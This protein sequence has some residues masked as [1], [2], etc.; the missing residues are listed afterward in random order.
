MAHQEK[1]SKRNLD[2]RSIKE[3]IK[4][5]GKK[6]IAGA[7]LVLIVVVAV[8]FALVFGIPKKPLE[9]E[10][11][12]RKHLCIASWPKDRIQYRHMQQLFAN[13]CGY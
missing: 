10:G 9:K 8:V 13:D 3:L 2:L 7:F 11:K 1:K 5:K 4:S 6:P 12:F